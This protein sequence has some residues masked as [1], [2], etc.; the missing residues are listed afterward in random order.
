M[1]NN[2]YLAKYLKQQKSRLQDDLAARGPQPPS[3]SAKGLCQ[4]ISP[5]SQVASGGKAMM[6]AISTSTQPTKGAAA[7]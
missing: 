5:G 6:S 1:W 2:T 7:R 3:G 4:C